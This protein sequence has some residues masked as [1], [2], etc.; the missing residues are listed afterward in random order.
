MK[1]S[2]CIY[3]VYLLLLSIITLVFMSC[4]DDLP[5]GIDSSDK[6][7]VLKSIQIVNAGVNGDITLDG[8]VDEKTKSVSFPRI[9]P[10][11]D[12]DNLRFEAVMSDGAK[13]EKDSYQVQFE[14]GKTERSMTI[15]VT[16]Q[17]R[18]REYYVN[19]RLKVPVFG[20]D[21]SKAVVHS[22]AGYPAFAGQMT[23]GSGFDGEYVLVVQ[24]TATPP[25]TPHLLR[26][27]DLK[28]N[29]TSNK[30]YLNMTGVSGGLYDV[31][32]GAQV[33]G[34]TYIGTLSTSQTNPIK[35]YHWADPTQAPETIVNVLG[36]SIPGAGVRH[37]DNMSVS[38]DENG[39]GFI[40][41]ISN[42]NPSR[43]LGFKVSNYKNVTES[44]VLNSNVNYGQWSSFLRV[45][46]TDSYLL[47]GY[48]N[49]IA[50]VNGQGTVSYTMG[51]LSIPSEGTDARVFTFNQ[52][53][54]MIMATVPRT[55]AETGRLYAYD[56]TK[57]DN[58][59]EALSYF[60][61]GSKAFA[62]EYVFAGVTNTAPSTQ[63]GWYIE[64]DQAGNDKKLYLFCASTDIGF[65][66]IEV[67]LAV[68]ED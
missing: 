42:D 52:K 53:R 40:H 16:N 22:F 23:R 34:H 38:L 49:P 25:S 39:N 28:N 43:I 51:N 64:K 60:E 1:K 56:I 36:Q 13:L 62:Y 35:I 18:F 31:N 26:V 6:F 30:I 21:F 68:A 10:A 45:G 24:R 67:P 59:V 4:K 29:V 33:N 48:K 50:V 11:T 66:F 54:Y 27:S 58:M 47:T 44:F 7:T 37:G 14:E 57:G 19:L 20:A 5:S 15:K 41:F 12:F 32:C 63:T 9:D 3:K 17:P 8:V 46:D 61:A 2:I 65:S 55:G